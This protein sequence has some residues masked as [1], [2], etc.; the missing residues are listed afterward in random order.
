MALVGFNAQVTKTSAQLLTPALRGHVV[1]NMMLIWNG[2]ESATP[3][4]PHEFEV[5]QGS[6]CALDFGGYL[7]RTPTVWPA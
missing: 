1:H 6:H 2:P 5:V 3:V 7:A 4:V